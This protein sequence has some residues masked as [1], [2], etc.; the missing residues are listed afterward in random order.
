MVFIFREKVIKELETKG[1]SVIPNVLA[2]DK[3]HQYIRVYKEWVEKFGDDRPYW[4]KSLM[5]QYRLSHCEPTWNVRLQTKSVFASLWK[6]EKLLTSMDGKAIG[7][8]PE[9]GNKQQMLNANYFFLA[10]IILLH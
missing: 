7:E 4:D 10:Q 9:L 3:C 6:T 8:P 5:Q 2:T 1:Y